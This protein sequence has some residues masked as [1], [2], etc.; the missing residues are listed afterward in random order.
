[1][2]LF[3]YILIVHGYIA[4]K[5]WYDHRARTQDKRVINHMVS[6]AANII[7]YLG[8]A[9]FLLYEKY[10]FDIFLAIL[11]LSFFWKR[12]LF[13]I[14]YNVLFNNKWNYCSDHSKIDNFIDKLDGQ[15][16][17]ICTY[18]LIIDVLA[19]ILGLLVIF[20]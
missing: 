10:S 20:V 19:I 8:S 9:Y 1:M 15:D 17:N 4:A 3:L 13:N 6:G 16:D 12:F 14:G 18:T 7:I 11:W 5:L 2:N